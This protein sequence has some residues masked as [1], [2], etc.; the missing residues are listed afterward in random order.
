MPVACPEL[1]CGCSS[2]SGNSNNP[3]ICR[4]FTI[5]IV[6][7]V[8]KISFGLIDGALIKNFFIFQLYS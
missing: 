5:G 2:G 1:S 7:M 3:N 4:V 8:L 6:G